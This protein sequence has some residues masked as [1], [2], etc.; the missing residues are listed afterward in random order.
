VLLTA[1][2]HPFSLTLT[3][4]TNSFLTLQVSRR[5][6]RPLVPD[7]DGLTS[8]SLSIDRPGVRLLESYLTSVSADPPASPVLRDLAS[9]HLVELAALALGPSTQAAEMARGGGVRAARLVAAKAVITRN[10]DSPGLSALAVAAQ[11]GVSPRYLHMLF[12]GEPLSFAEF[13]TDRRL[14]RACALLADP[15]RRHWRIL[16]IA[17]EVG[18]GDIGAFNRAFRR[19]RDMTPSEFRRNAQARP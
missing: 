16:D 13:V 9:R 11:L 6:L 1:L 12:D 5:A 14:A 4:P 10:L 15:A 2:D 17:F 19:R 7:L 3:E 18:F 8:G